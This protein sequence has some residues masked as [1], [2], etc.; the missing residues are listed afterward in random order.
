MALLRAARDAMRAWP[1]S[2]GR[3]IPRV[4][5][6]LYIQVVQS[7]GR[8]PGR[9]P[10]TSTSSCTPSHRSPT[11]SPRRSAAGAPDDQ[12]PRRCVWCALAEAEEESGER[13]IFADHHAVVFAPA[14]SRSA[15]EMMVVPRQHAA[16]FTALDDEAI[17][18]HRDPP[19]HPPC[20]RRARRPA[21]QPLPAHVA[22]GRAAG[23]DVPLALGDPSAPARDRRTRARDRAGG[24]P[25]R[26]RVRRRGPPGAGGSVTDAGGLRHSPVGGGLALRRTRC[27]RRWRCR[28]ARWSDPA[29]SGRDDAA[30]EAEVRR[31]VRGVLRPDLQLRAAHGQRPRPRRR[32]HPGHLHQGLP[33][34]RHR[35]RGNLDPILALPDRHEHRDRRHAPAAQGQPP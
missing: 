20:A 2:R 14:A 9:G 8:R 28:P 35:H 12:E 17:A 22:G 4:A 1:P 24:E 27:I 10:R 5:G 33:Q 13:L 16:D 23:P 34:A 18:D 6:A 3:R 31:A 30:L 21:L 11:G 19:A 25:G 15:F 32:H 26:A 29:M 7:Y